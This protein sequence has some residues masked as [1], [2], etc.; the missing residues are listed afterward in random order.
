MLTKHPLSGKKETEPHLLK[1][2]PSNSPKMAKT[3]KDFQIRKSP[4]QLLPSSP[5]PK[6]NQSAT[7]SSFYRP[8]SIR[9][10]TRDLKS[11]LL[12]FREK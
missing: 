2:Q 7:L 4:K 8:D 1:F 5:S 12:S 9:G 10:D 3:S 6:N 11:K